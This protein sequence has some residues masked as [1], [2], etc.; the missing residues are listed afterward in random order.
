MNSKIIFVCGTFFP[1]TSGGPDNSNY[2][3]A[4]KLQKMGYDVEI[5]SF[6]RNIQKIDIKKYSI[7]PNKKVLIN[8]LPV[9]YFSY[10][11]TRLFSYNFCR[12][13]NW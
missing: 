5:I 13:S 7:K 2:W 6:F 4:S 1:A 10:V 12:K 8:G 9:T 3:L 11:Q